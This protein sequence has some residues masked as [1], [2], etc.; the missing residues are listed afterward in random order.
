MRHVLGLDGIRGI[1]V[2]LVMLFHF[3]YLAAGWIGVQIFFA[4]SGY[5]IT[6]ILLAD[7]A[8][9]FSAFAGRFYWRRTLRIFPLILVFLLLLAAIYRFSGAP[10]SFAADWP[11]LLTFTANFARMREGD[12]GPHVVHMWSLAVEEQFYLVWPLLLFFVPVAMFRWVVAAFLLGAPVLRLVVFQAL[13]GAGFDEEYAGKAAC[14]LP[15]MQFDAFA[16]GAA[17]PLWRLDRMRHAG[18]LLVATTCVAAAAGLCMLAS[19]HF[20]GEGAFVSS[21]GFAHLLVQGHGYVWG[22]SLLNVLSMLWIVCTI[23]GIGPA[24]LLENRGMVWV[25][26]VSYG[27]YVY[28]LPILFAGV[29]VAERMDLQLSGGLRLVFFAAWVIT[30]MAVAGASYKWLEMP[31]LKLKDRWQT[32]SKVESLQRS[33]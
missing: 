12:L 25:G 11:W 10:A 1:A 24:Q 17:I 20:R 31:F 7:K 21:L 9:S 30:V 26:K 2:L 32:R 8:S 5:L 13:L 33:S 14:V 6:S 18:R 28:H 23:Q 29:F 27:I 3:G 16:A 15:F 4:L 22:Y 19:Q